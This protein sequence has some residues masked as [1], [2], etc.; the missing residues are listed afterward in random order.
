MSNPRYR[1]C[2]SHRL[3]EL[4]SVPAKLEVTVAIDPCSGIENVDGQGTWQRDG[5]FLPAR[6]C[7][8]QPVAC[9]GGIAAE[10]MLC[11]V[12][13]AFDSDATMTEFPRRL[14]EEIACGGVVHVNV[15]LI[16]KHEL[17]LSKGIAWS[18]RLTEM[19]LEVCGRDR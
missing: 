19:K 8:G 6:D 13:R 14:L 17:Q 15:E 16:G 11:Q 1:D 2:L 3:I 9:P 18:R 5:E 10:C 7:G 12:Q 4:V